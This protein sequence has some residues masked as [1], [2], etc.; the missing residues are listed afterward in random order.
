MTNEEQVEP[1][2]RSVPLPGL[3]PDEPPVDVAPPPVLTPDD[4]DLPTNDQPHLNIAKVKGLYQWQL[5]SANG[6][7]LAFSGSR[8]TTMRE[9]KADLKRTQLE[10]PMA[11]VI[12]LY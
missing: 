6:K 2:V 1:T 4:V 5:I 8:Y 10:L 12:K 3:P 11:S 7:S 9:L